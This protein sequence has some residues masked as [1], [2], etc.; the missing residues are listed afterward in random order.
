MVRLKT[1]AVAIL[2]RAKFILQALLAE[3]LE[4]ES[5]NLLHQTLLSARADVAWWD[6]GHRRAKRRAEAKRRGA[7]ANA[8]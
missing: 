1:A 7:T 8:A 6:A 5:S 2:K 3:R 4:R